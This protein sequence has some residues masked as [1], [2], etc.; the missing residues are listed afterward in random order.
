MTHYSHC[1][2]S[3]LLACLGLGSIS[4]Y[5]LHHSSTVP[6]MIVRR[7]LG[8]G[9]I[10]GSETIPLPLAT[11]KKKILVAIDGS[12]ASR[13]ALAW[14]LNNRQMLDTIHIVSAP[15]EP[16]YPLLDEVAAVAMFQ[17]QHHDQ[18]VEH[19]I[20][21]CRE[22]L[23]AAY[24]QAWREGG[25]LKHHIVTRMLEGSGCGE[26]SR[27]ICAYSIREEV[28]LVVIGSRGMGAMK[29]LLMDAIGVGSVSQFLAHH[30]LC[31]MVV[32]REDKD[33]GK[34]GEKE[35]KGLKEQLEQKDGQSMRTASNEGAATGGVE[36]IAAAPTNPSS[37]PPSSPASHPIPITAH[38]PLS[39]LPEIE[40]GNFG[41]KGGSGSGSGGHGGSGQKIRDERRGVLVENENE[42]EVELQA[43]DFEF[44]TP[45]K[46]NSIRLPANVN[47]TPSPHFSSE[48]K[49]LGLQPPPGSASSAAASGHS[50]AFFTLL[51]P[52]GS[53]LCSLS[54]KAQS[55][56][57][58]QG[59]GDGLT[60]MPATPPYL[61]D[62]S[63]RG[64]A[65]KTADNTPSSPLPTSDSTKGGGLAMGAMDPY[66]RQSSTLGG[67]ENHSPHQPLPPASPIFVLLAPPQHEGYSPPSAS[68]S[69]SRTPF[70][71]LSPLASNLSFVRSQAP[72]PASIAS[73]YQS[74]YGNQEGA[75]LAATASSPTAFSTGIESDLMTMTSPMP[76]FSLQVPSSPSIAAAAA[77]SGGI[78]SSPSRAVAGPGAVTAGPGPAGHADGSATKTPK[79]IGSAEA[80][81]ALSPHDQGTITTPSTE[82]GCSGF[83]S[84]STL[85]P[86]RSSSDAKSMEQAANDSP[87]SDSSQP[88]FGQPSFNQASFGRQSSFNQ[89]PSSTH[90]AS[91]GQFFPAAQEA[92]RNGPSATLADLGR[93]V[94][95][96]EVLG[97]KNMG[98]SEGSSGGKSKAESIAASSLSVR[99]S[100]S[101]TDA[102][103]E[104]KR[105]LS[106]KI[107]EGEEIDD[108]GLPSAGEGGGAGGEGGHLSALV[109]AVPSEKGKKGSKG[110]GG[111]SSGLGQE[112]QSQLS[113][114][115][116][117]S[118]AG[119]LRS[120]TA[121]FFPHG[122][123][124]A[125]SSVEG[126]G[127]VEEED[128]E[129]K[130]GEGES[131]DETEEDEGDGSRTPM[132]SATSLI[133][134]AS[135]AALAALNKT[136]S[137]SQ[138]NPGSSSAVKA[139]GHPLEELVRKA[140]E[141]AAKAA[142]QSPI[143]PSPH[144][145]PSPAAGLPS[146]DAGEPNRSAGV[147][148]GMGMGGEK[149]GW[150]VS[151]EFAKESLE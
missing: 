102:E 114:W 26:I 12:P 121:S 103:A 117:A 3:S 5:C 79:S 144:P 151:E 138:V 91:A 10:I 21:S 107:N 52:L 143:Q 115:G 69:I 87:F 56:G 39:A 85:S 19:S 28:D 40:E 124:P 37:S 24:D 41:S 93:G 83:L 42:N 70:Q 50:P 135:A 48:K 101:E 142:G 61:P 77:A 58:G 116:S 81:N 75:G 36:V 84:W 125:E 59:Q 45:E 23:D 97:V 29:S 6:V 105:I 120:I 131:S 137:S 22:L 123:Y 33:Q 89:P 51:N 96:V 15:E 149:E 146:K 17:M 30:L 88:Q 16:R 111:P 104:R 118:D 34:E 43:A 127:A 148:A 63:L 66:G 7:Q 141:A 49:K 122:L 55:Q 130:K 94:K 147:G 68:S 95:G 99:G 76:Q 47:F 145:P 109:G 11:T 86:L 134:E 32:V 74:G 60:P 92:M 13:S 46:V 73:P 65:F 112:D 108:E 82:G 90:S 136:G 57:Q 44:S 71:D 129:E 35:K 78:E 25:V 110:G 18:D 9:T 139:E 119:S 126:I 1:K 38:K 2:H 150:L 53:P 133:A 128:E 106:L 113:N 20:Q 72:S 31:P 132:N 140:K 64:V 80:S 27:A 8:A 98:S 62:S 100:G 4:D 67:K 14:T 54:A